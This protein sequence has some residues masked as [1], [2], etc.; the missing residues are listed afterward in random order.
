[1][2]SHAGAGWKSVTNCTREFGE[3][4][5]KITGTETVTGD[6]N[7]KYTMKSHRVTAGEETRTTDITVN[8]VYKGACPAGQKAGDITIDGRTFNALE[9]RGG[10]G[11]GG[12]GG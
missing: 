6:L 1:M 3:N 4:T 8:G 2:I 11:G 9:G 7:A 5:M 12:R 10:G